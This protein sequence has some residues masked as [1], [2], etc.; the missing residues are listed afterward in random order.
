MPVALQ[1]AGGW[2]PSLTPVTYWCKLL[3]TRSFVAYLQLEVT[4]V[5][6]FHSRISKRPTFSDVGFFFG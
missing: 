2:L 4:W 1:D 3:G 5:Y 6:A